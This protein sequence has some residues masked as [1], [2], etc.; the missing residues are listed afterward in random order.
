MR[1]PDLAGEEVHLVK[2]LIPLARPGQV[3]L[4]ARLHYRADQVRWSLYKV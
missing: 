1:L 3:H 2:M 4:S